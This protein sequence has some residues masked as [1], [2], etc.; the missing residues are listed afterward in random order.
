MILWSCHDHT[1][2]MISNMIILWSHEIYDHYYDNVL[3]RKWISSKPA[4][5]SSRCNRVTGWSFCHGLVMETSGASCLTGV[6]KSTLPCS[7][8]CIRAMAAMVFEIEPA[9][10]SVLEFTFL[11]SSMEAKLMFCS[12]STP[13]LWLIESYKPTK[14]CAF[15]I[16]L[17]SFTS[18]LASLAFI[19][20]LSLA[21]RKYGMN[22]SKQIACTNTLISDFNG[23]FSYWFRSLFA[24]FDYIHACWQH[25]KN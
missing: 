22:N 4:V 21:L 9:L 2:F 13:S 10:N 20:E 7:T 25:T 5:C 12:S 1:S 18:V 8:S 6:F 14:L 19:I 3:I 16:E 23:V 17:I 11:L 24:L 15:A